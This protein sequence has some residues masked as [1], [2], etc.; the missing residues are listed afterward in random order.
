MNPVIKNIL[1]FVVIG[2]ILASVYFFVIKKPAGEDVNL[3]SSSGASALPV[4]TPITANSTSITSSDSSLF[5]S[6]LLNV[7][8]I[9]LNDGIFADPAFAKLRDSSIELVP[10]GNEGRPNPFAPIG[11]DVNNFPITSDILVVPD[12]ST[13]PVLD[14]GTAE[15]VPVPAPAPTPTNQ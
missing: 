8:N 15:E 12:V 4:A 7:K 14:Q 5:L 11:S 2:G 6:V 3:V 1:I 13:P 10:D 9:S